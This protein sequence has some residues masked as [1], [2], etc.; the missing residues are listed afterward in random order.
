MTDYE[1]HYVLN[2]PC[3]TQL[4]GDTED[5]IVEVATAHLTEKHPGRDYQREDILFMAQ[6]L[7]KGKVS[8]TLTCPCGVALTGDDEDGIV[9]AVNLH[10]KMSHGGQAGPYTKEQILGMAQKITS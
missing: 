4:T 10:L 1:L 8:Y 5:D 7:V 9:F 3:G 6:R 2:C